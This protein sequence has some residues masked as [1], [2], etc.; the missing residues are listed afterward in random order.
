MCVRCASHF[1][2]RKRK[3]SAVSVPLRLN[4]EELKKKGEA[5]KRKQD[6]QEEPEDEE[7][8]GTKRTLAITG[9]EIEEQSRL[10]ET[11]QVFCGV[12]FSQLRSER[13][14]CQK[15]IVAIRASD[16][17]LVLAHVPAHQDFIMGKDN[18]AITSPTGEEPSEQESTLWMCSTDLVVHAKVYA[19]A[20]K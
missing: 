5:Q 9:K 1:V 2:H 7:D 19:L 8:G 14:Q 12:V 18:A 3:C 17:A 16:A 15:V 13:R 4:R 20:E 11:D 10:L 6:L